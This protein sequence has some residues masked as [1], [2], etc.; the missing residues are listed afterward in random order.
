MENE[1]ELELA[2]KT[3]WS[4]PPGTLLPKNYIGRII[5]NGVVFRFFKDETNNYFYTSSIA[6]QV[7]LE[8]RNSGKRREKTEYA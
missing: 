7:E 8:L 2:Y 4:I 6:D 3:A 1:K 5:K